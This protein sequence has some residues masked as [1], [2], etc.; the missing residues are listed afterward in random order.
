MTEK[1]RFVKYDGYLRFS[2]IDTEQEKYL[3]LDEVIYL[4]NKLNDENRQLR[5]QAAEY[6]D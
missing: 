3:Y 2:C 6:D 5:K 1:K 4:L